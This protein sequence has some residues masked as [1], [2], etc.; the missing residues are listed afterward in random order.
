[1]LLKYYSPYI[2]IET[3]S[4]AS[5]T[6]Q[7]RSGRLLPMLELGVTP[8]HVSIAVAD[9]DA[10]ETA[11]ADSAEEE[12][13]FCVPLESLGLGGNLITCAGAI[14][15]ASSLKTNTSRSLQYIIV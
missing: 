4:Q 5:L 6:E 12:N 13:T 14:M 1:M 15:L 8:S 10:S 9:E 2:I 3:S 11:A 7:V